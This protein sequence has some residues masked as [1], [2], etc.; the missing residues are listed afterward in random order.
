MQVFE[1]RATTAIYVRVKRYS[2][3]HFVLCDEYEIVDKLKGR[4]LIMLEQIGF[5]LQGQGEDP[6]TT[7]D[8]RLCNKKRVSSSAQNIVTPFRPFRFSMEVPPATISRSSTTRS[9]GCSSRSLARRTSM[10]T[11]VLVSCTESAS[12]RVVDEFTF[13]LWIGL[14]LPIVL[15]MNMEWLFL[16]Q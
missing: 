2:E 14:R 1:E 6:L 12:K 11:R 13:E 4:L 7:E 9:C 3:T 15:Y 10:T 5:K 8:I 16:C